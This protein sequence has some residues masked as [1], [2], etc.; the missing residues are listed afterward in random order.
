MKDVKIA[1]LDMEWTS[2]KGSASRNWSLSY[3][4]KEIVQIGIV[5]TKNINAYTTVYGN[6]A[7]EKK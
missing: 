5:V 7:K 6:P 2:W 3:E 4:K 1:I